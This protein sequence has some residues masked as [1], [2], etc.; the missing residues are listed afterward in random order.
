ME[1]EEVIK[2]GSTCEEV[3]PNKGMKHI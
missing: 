1:E 2:K 3:L